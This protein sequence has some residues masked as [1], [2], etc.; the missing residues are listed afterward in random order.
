MSDVWRA[1]CCRHC[2]NVDNDMHYRDAVI[3]NKSNQI[4]LNHECCDLFKMDEKEG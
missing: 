1:R 2:K 3:C 4:R